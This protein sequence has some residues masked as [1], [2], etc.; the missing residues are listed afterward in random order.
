M[1]KNDRYLFSRMCVETVN[2]ANIFK[3]SFS[4]FI[5]YGAII[6]YAKM[7]LPDVPFD[8]AMLHKVYIEQQMLCTTSIHIRLID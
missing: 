6:I 5:L 3:A 4:L 7:L 1:K 8:C 2:V